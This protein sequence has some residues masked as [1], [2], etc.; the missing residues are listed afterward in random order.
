ME[1]KY[2]DIELYREDNKY[3]AYISED[4]SSGYSIKGNSAKHCGELVKEY[5][6]NAFNN[7]EE[8]L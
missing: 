8:D 4:G 1:S 2:L 7:L 6:I 3:C 5:I